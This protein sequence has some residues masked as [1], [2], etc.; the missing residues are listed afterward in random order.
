M[1]NCYSFIIQ[2]EVELQ[3]LI[4]VYYDAWQNVS[5]LLQNKLFVSENWHMYDIS[6]NAAISFFN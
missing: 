4:K 5:L 1:P 6:K 3:L 2:T